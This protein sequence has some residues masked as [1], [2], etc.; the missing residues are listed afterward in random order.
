MAENGPGK[1]VITGADGFVGSALVAHCVA[2]GRPFVAVVRKPPAEGTA[3]AHVNA[4]QI[5]DLATASDS[6]LDGIVAGTVAIVHLA[7]RAHVMAESAPDPAALYHAANVVALERMAAAA[8]RGGVR[9]LVLASTI[10]VHGESTVPGRPF[11]AEDALVP[12]DAYARSKVEAEQRLAAIAKGT[13]LDTVVLRLPLVYGPRVKGNFLTLLDA[14]AR[15]APLPFGKIA[16]RRDLLYVGNLVQAIVALV[17]APGTVG[18]AWLAADGEAV[19]TAE[20]VRRIASA[21]E[22]PP[23]V[24]NVPKPLVV[25]AARATGRGAMIARTVESLEVDA[26]PLANRIGPPFFTL[27]RGLAA[28]AA[29]WKLRHSI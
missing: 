4:T 19:S 20:L 17:D 23:R 11:R 6:A 21:L 28:T 12:N 29:W 18:G 9:R 16:N 13:S 14:V 2:T 26:S 8:V 15:S 22:V 3:N 1:I 24:L 10:K 5:A 25:L 7:G 27:D